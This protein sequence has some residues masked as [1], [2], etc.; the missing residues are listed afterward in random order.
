[1]LLEEI[2][3]SSVNLRPIC[4]SSLLPL[5]FLLSF[6]HPAADFEIDHSYSWHKQASCWGDITGSTGPQRGY[7][8]PSQSRALRTENHPHADTNGS[9]NACCSRV[10]NVIIPARAGVLA[11]GKADQQKTRVTTEAF[12]S[13]Y[14]DGGCSFI[15][16]MASAEC[17]MAAPALI[18]AATQM[19]SMISFSVAPF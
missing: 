15:T 8:W 6:A 19:A 9:N 2:G 5:S 14:S 17:A 10:A 13:P 3:V 16:S 4:R 1:M 7:R 11:E 12:P 18:S